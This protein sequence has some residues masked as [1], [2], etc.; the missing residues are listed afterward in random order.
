MDIMEAKCSLKQ[1]AFNL[2][3]SKSK[4]MRFIKFKCIDTNKLKHKFGLFLVLLE[5]NELNYVRMIHSTQ[6][7]SFPQC[8]FMMSFHNFK[9]IDIL[10][11]WVFQFVDSAEITI[12]YRILNLIFVHSITYSYKKINKLSYNR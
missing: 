7:L 11:L 12:S 6:Y 4:R 2:L 8:N 5:I 3:L 9:S 10:S 1:Y